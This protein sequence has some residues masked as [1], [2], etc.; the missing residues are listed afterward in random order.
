MGISDAD[1]KLWPKVDQAAKDLE[2]KFG[3]QYDSDDVMGDW[4]MLFTTSVAYRQQGG[5]TGL[6]KAPGT[7]LHSLFQILRKQRVPDSEW[8]EA[9]RTLDSVDEA[10]QIS[11]QTPEGI[12][13][14]AEVLQVFGSALVKN[15]M[16]GVFVLDRIDEQG[17]KFTGVD[18]IITKVTNMYMQTYLL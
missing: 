12:A 18:Q 16:R 15:E 10:E 14:T 8:N 3:Y 4:R 6:A 1:V 17:R 2:A 5:M 9:L 11:G 7:A 13:A